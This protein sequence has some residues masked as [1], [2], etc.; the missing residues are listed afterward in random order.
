[1]RRFFSTN[2]K[3]EADRS[4]LEND[5]NYTSNV[6]TSPDTTAPSHTLPGRDSLREPEYTID[7][8]YTSNVTTAPSHTLPGRDSVW[9]REYTIG[10]PG[11][12]QVVT[13]NYSKSR[14]PS[15]SSLQFSF[16]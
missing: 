4:V 1:M 12:S 5:S 10:V 7:S 14:C 3:A 15:V 9:Q 2:R 11:S 16:V 6:T 13:P 8:T